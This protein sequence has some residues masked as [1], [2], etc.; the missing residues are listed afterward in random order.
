MAD[1]FRSDRSWSFDVSRGDLWERIS[2]TDAYPS[3]WPWLRRFEASGGLA[4]D[5]RWSCSVSPPLPYTVDFE[6]RFDLVDPARLVH[7]TVTGDIG[8][9]ARLMLDDAGDGCRARLVSTLRPTNALLRG[10][11]L[12][13]RPLVEHGH[14]WILDE[15]RRQFVERAFDDR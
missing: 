5:E 11:G 15:G 10:V 2:A 9:T 13:A 14:D 6:V 4:A 7:A 8:G 3:W 12:I 1:P